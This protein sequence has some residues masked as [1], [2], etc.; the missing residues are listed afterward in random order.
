MWN[1]KLNT[2]LTH[3]CDED[4][5]AL[6]LKNGETAQFELYN[7]Y[8]VRFMVLTRRYVYNYQ[9]IDDVYQDSFIRIFRSL[10]ALKNREL[11]FPWAKQIFI[12]TAI[13]FRKGKN[14]FIY[15][16]IETIG[17]MSSEIE[18]DF[19]KISADE[20]ESA[21]NLLATNQK[22]VFNLYVLDEFSHQEIANILKIKE[23]HSRVI[24]TRARQQLKKILIEKFDFKMIESQIK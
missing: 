1:K 16:E 15:D 12:R 10:E 6:C 9:D 21:I 18:I 4:L 14:S 2:S 7:R 19:G 20:I 5:I 17:E 3:I 24:L 13:N 22:L 23:S 8:K 11:F